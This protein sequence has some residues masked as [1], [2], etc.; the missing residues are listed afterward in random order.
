M[1]GEVVCWVGFLTNSLANFVLCKTLGSHRTWQRLLQISFLLVKSL[2]KNWAV[3]IGVSQMSNDCNL[4]N[5]DVYI[6][7][8]CT[9]LIG[10]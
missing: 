10:F 1:F 5:Y 9:V 6:Y 8:L 3:F 4:V 7:I 2:G